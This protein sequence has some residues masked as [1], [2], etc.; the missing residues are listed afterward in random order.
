MYEIYFIAVAFYI[1]RAVFP[2]I[3]RR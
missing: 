1:F 3:I 2:S